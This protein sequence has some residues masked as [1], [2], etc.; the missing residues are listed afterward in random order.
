MPDTTVTKL[1]ELVPRIMDRW[2]ERVREEVPAAAL[3]NQVFLRNELVDMLEVLAKN[4]ADKTDPKTEARDTAYIT[5]HAKERAESSEYSL[6]QI[7]LEI[8]ILQEVVLEELEVN[9]LLNSS[10]RNH[11]IRYLSELIRIAAAEYVRVQTERLKQDRLKDEFMAMLG[12]E[13]R[14]PLGAISTSLSV[15]RKSANLS[16]GPEHALEVAYRQ[17]QHMKRMVNDLLDLSRITAGTVDLKLETLDLGIVVQQAVENIRESVDSKG[18]TISVSLP[19]MQLHVQADPVRLEQC[20]SN[21]LDNAAKYTRK[22]GRIEVAVLRNDEDAVVRIRDNGI[23]IAPELLPNIFDLFQQASRNLDRTEG[24][25]GIGLS[26]VKRLVELQGGRVEAKSEGLGKGSEFLIFLPTVKEPSVEKELDQ[27]QQGKLSVRVLIVEDNE[28]AAEML[29]E[30]LSLSGHHVEVAIDGP[31]A[32]NKVTNHC[33]DVA[34]VDI[35][36]PGMTGYELAA[37]L[38]ASGNCPPSM[39]LIAITGYAEDVEALERA[40]F[41]HHMSK[42][43]DLDE[44]EDILNQV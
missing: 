15:L 1:R 25:L 21:L 28:D 35:G 11:V 5:L 3:Q 14:N 30:V 39:K 27:P 26:V 9:G 41:D 24:G 40:G 22:G 43:L 31:T 6:E 10:D 16:G 17:V 34:L 44:L 18:H 20:L 12:H 23:G 29:R 7:I 8:Q 13:L 19:P 4:M 36:L 38:R 42:P 33:P 2:D 37:K 32:L